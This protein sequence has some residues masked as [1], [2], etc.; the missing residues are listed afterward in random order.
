[1]MNKKC[2]TLREE[3]EEYKDKYLRSLA[4]LENYKKQAVKERAEI[5]QYTRENMLVDFI[6]VVDDFE[7]ALSALKLVNALNPQ[8]RETKSDSTEKKGKSVEIPKIDDFYKGV[9]LIYN[10]FLAFLDSKGV[11]PFSGK[12]TKFDPRLHEVVG[13][14]ESKDTED[15]IIVKE[16]CRGYAL[17]DKI[18]RP[19]KVIVSKV[20]DSAQKVEIEIKDKNNQKDAPAKVEI[21]PPETEKAS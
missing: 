7:H 10:N 5:L 8:D 1:M 12:G 20:C 16:L 15:G 2:K 17:N 11:K 4:E 9:E 18:L 21:I 6:R 3:A 14:E 19:A 13:V